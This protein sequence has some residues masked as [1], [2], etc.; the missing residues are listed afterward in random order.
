MSGDEKTGRAVERVVLA[1]STS[2]GAGVRLKRS[3]GS[4]ALELL[5]PFLLLDEFGSDRKDDSLGGFPDH[6]HRGF[7]TVTYMLEGKMEHRDHLGNHGL[8]D[9]GS[10]QWMSAGHGIIHSEMPKQEDG[11]MWGFQLWVNLPAS[12]KMRPPRY[13]DIPP[14]AIAEVDLEGGHRVRVVAGTFR[15]VT[16]PVREIVTEPLYLDFHLHPGVPIEIPLP[17]RHNAFCYCYEG[18]LTAGA[19]GQKLHAGSFAVLGKGDR[20][21]I[22]ALDRLSR[23]LV[24]AGKPIGEPVARYGPF[25]MNTREEII[26]AIDDYRSGRLL[27]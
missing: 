24:V 8:L 19:N 5:D 16:G 18:D 3:L 23:C 6:P 14:S 25:V 22:T 27:L 21:A 10:V 20:L 12:D 13:Q 1:Q 11:K 2:D 7:E 26:Q 15:G 9:S 4:A 17:E